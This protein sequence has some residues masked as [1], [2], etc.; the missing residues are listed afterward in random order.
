MEH[1]VLWLLQREPVWIRTNRYRLWIP[2]LVMLCFVF[3]DNFRPADPRGRLRLTPFEIDLDFG[4]SSLLYSL[5]K[6]PHLVYFFVFSLFLRRLWG[7]LGF[8]RAFVFV[9]MVSVWIE[10]HQAFTAGRSA[11]PYDVLPN[12][13]GL[14]LAWIYVESRVTRGRGFGRE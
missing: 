3:V 9:L 10:L 14:R 7:K 6:V 1:I 4:L 5:S 2:I 13:I 11:R 8:R 12:L